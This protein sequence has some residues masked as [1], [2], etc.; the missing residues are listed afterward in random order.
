MT[1]AAHET[2]IGY[3]GKVPSRDDFIKAAAY[4]ALIEALDAWL[5]QGMELLAADPNWKRHYDSF[6]PAHFAF[7]GPRNPR[8]IAGHLVASRDQAGRRFPFI[9]VG[10]MHGECPATFTRYSPMVLSRL[11]TRLEAQT[12]CAL[13]AKD[14]S[15]PLHVLAANRIALDTNAGGYDAAFEDFLDMQTVGSTATLLSHAGFPGSLRQL[16]L[17]LGLLLQ[18]VLA[19]L[20]S[21]LEKC[22]LLPLPVDPLYRYLVATYW[23][24]LVTPFLERADFE[25]SLLLLTRRESGPAMLI[26]FNGASARMLHAAIDPQGAADHRITFDDADWVED[27]LRQTYDVSK[28]SAYLSEPAL[29]L[30]AARTAFLETFLGI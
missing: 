4:P 12:D 19:S 23:M 28:L 17:A 7:L 22:L 2:V 29:S 9:A 18:P 3:F 5:A 6:T 25:L 1:S 27:R 24:H 10:A 14:A 13:S 15:E 30:K 11:W 21:R 8:A 16:M 20:S 26:G